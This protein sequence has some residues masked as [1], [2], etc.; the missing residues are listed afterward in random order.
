MLFIFCFIIFV[1]KYKIKGYYKMGC[2]KKFKEN[3]YTVGK[4]KDGIFQ[5]GTDVN[6]VTK[7]GLPV[8][9]SNL[10]LLSLVDKTFTK[11]YPK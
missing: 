6:I 1:K 4:I 8:S 2:W 5:N 9:F 3:F 7:P 10:R 11:E